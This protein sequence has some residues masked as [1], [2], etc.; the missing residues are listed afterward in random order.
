MKSKKLIIG[1]ISAIALLIFIFI[2]LSNNKNKL[3]Y[4]KN[5]AG[6]P[7]YPNTKLVVS[8]D[9]PN[10]H[11]EVYSSTDT[12][13]SFKKVIKFYKNNI[14][15]NIWTISKIDDTNANN[16]RI[17]FLENNNK[18]IKITIDYHPELYSELN[19]AFAVTIED[20]ISK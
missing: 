12:K 13:E 17:F 19:E 10:Y 15:S 14:D 11:K 9:N 1:L 5:F 8:V 3:D 2:C 18:K 4:S 6:I 20:S 16:Q 7:I